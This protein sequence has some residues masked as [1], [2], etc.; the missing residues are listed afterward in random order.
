MRSEGPAA[1]AGVLELSDKL[2]QLSESEE[3]QVED[4][5]VDDIV[6]SHD[7]TDDV[8]DDEADDDDED[9]DETAAKQVRSFPIVIS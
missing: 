4:K 6:V 2:S 5:Q 9:E 3:R 8:V 1:C 7:D